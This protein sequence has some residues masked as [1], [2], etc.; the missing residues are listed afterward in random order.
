MTAEKRTLWDYTLE[1][2]AEN[3]AR[4]EELCSVDSG[5]VYTAAEFKEVA[6]TLTPKDG[7]DVWGLYQGLEA[8][9]TT[10]RMEWNYS[11]CGGDRQK[12][13]FRS[14]LCDIPRPPLAKTI[15][16]RNRP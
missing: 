9:G 7:K 13:K 16:P 15:L 1:V 3:G 6:E 2:M 4:E 14:R 5:Y 10:W 8:Y 12:W 11:D